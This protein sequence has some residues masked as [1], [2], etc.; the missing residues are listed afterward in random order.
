MLAAF[1]ARHEYLQMLIF[2]LEHYVRFFS[3]KHA[4]RRGSNVVD[5]VDIDDAVKH[6]G[7]PERFIKSEFKDTATLN[8]VQSARLWLF[9]SMK[10]KMEAYESPRVLDAGCGWGRWIIKLHNYCQRDFEMVGV[11]LD[12]FSL[13]YALT[14]D[15]LLSVTRSNVDHLPF[16]NDLFDLILCSAVIHEIKTHAS[17]EKTIG[18][19]RRILKPGGTLYIIDAFSTNPVLSMI[20]S[21]LQ[22]VTSRAEWM[23]EEAQLRRILEADD[24]TVV[25]AQRMRYRMFGAIQVSMIVS[26]KKQ[27]TMKC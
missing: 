25:K 10:K 15:K 8:T 23:F 21:L 27:A 19:F 11:D 4:R 12:E 3:I 2:D 14:L 9:E 16:G 24:F 5:T 17:R 20:L 18:E 22:H 6:F 1:G 26:M 13:R 7:K